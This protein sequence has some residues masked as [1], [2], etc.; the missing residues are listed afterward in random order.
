MCLEMILKLYL[1]DKMLT[2][3]L[4]VGKKQS[5]TLP[6]IRFQNDWNLNVN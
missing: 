4:Q 1:K 2:K 6:Q 3:V 5:Q